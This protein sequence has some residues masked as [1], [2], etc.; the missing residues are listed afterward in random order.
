MLDT[1][2]GEQPAHDG[3]FA[4]DGM[5]MSELVLL[6]HLVRSS[7]SRTALEIGMAHGTST[8]VIAAALPA[9][10]QLTSVDPFQRTR[11]AGGGLAAVA[12]AGHAGKHALEDTPDYVA[13]PRLFEDDRRYD[14]IFIDGYHSTDF[15]MVDLFYGDLLLRDGGTLAFHDSSVPGVY[16][17]VR[18]LERYKPYER[19]GPPAVVD[20]RSRAARIL[21]RIG[22]ALCGPATWRAARERRALWRSLSAYRKLPARSRRSTRCAELGPPPVTAR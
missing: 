4:P 2:Y 18:F 17:V 14:F 15:V 13:L 8:V 1:A 12:R 22:Y 16:E 5:V 19:L 6:H 10:G 9:D 11:Y 21:R 7:R 20:L 3:A